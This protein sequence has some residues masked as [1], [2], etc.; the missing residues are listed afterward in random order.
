MLR[1]VLAEHR[2]PGL[3]GEESEARVRSDVEGIFDGEVILAVEL[4]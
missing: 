4:E 3:E 2:G 1:H